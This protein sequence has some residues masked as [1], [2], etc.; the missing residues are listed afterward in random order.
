[1][2][3]QRRTQR[4][5]EI[6]DLR[7]AGK[8]AHAQGIKRTAVPWKPFQS[9]NAEHWLRGWDEAEEEQRRA[10]EDERV[11]K[12]HS[13]HDR[14]VATIDLFE[15]NGDRATLA[16]ILRYMAG[17]LAPEPITDLTRDDYE[18][19]YGWGGQG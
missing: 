6:A 8:L 19:I 17:R 16:A 11:A 3:N 1:M 18:A 2:S 4:K 9:M 14:L 7:M 10:V 15:H 12:V 5:R 13:A